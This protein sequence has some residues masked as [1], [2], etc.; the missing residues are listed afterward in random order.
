MQG[1]DLHGAA[2][3]PDGTIHKA[4]GFFLN[5]IEQPDL[6]LKYAWVNHAP[7][8]SQNWKVQDL[9]SYGDRD[10]SFAWIAPYIQRFPDHP[11]TRRL[12]ARRNSPHSEPTSYLTPALDGAVRDNGYSVDWIG[13]DARCL[14]ADPRFG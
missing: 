2:P 4:V 11:N 3:S 14:Y 9:S 10:S 12:L 1:I 7:G 5:S 13:V 8:P 6:V